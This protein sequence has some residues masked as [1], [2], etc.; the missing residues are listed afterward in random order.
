MLCTGRLQIHNTCQQWGRQ[1][2][3]R[4]F[5]SSAVQC[6]TVIGTKRLERAIHRRDSKCCIASNKRRHPESMSPVPDSDLHAPCGPSWRLDAEP[7]PS[8]DRNSSCA[9]SLHSSPWSETQVEPRREAIAKTCFRDKR[10][11]T[12]R[13]DGHRQ[14]HKPL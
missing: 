12:I 7:Q 11:E 6:G 9:A 4:A 13:E 1:I 2:E 10:R 5:R 8:D 14:R 3:D